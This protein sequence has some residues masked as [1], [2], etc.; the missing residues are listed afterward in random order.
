MDNRMNVQREIKRIVKYLWPYEE[1]HYWEGG[2]R[3]NHIFKSLRFLND[4]F[5]CGCKED[6]SYKENK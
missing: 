3:R 6:K 5:N 1:E 2:D 4:K